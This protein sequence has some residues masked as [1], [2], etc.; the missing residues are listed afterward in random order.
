MTRQ[1]K[2]KNKEQEPHHV[3][4]V[5]HDSLLMNGCRSSQRYTLN[6][7]NIVVIYIVLESFIKR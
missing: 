6:K 3:C 4:H 7:K 1:R 2:L 5:L